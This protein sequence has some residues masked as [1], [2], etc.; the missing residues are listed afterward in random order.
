[1]REE[2]LGPFP[3]YCTNVCIVNR[4]IVSD[5]SLSEILGVTPFEQHPQIHRGDVVSVYY[6][7]S[8]S[9]RNSGTVTIWHN[10]SHAAIKTYSATLSGEWL[11]PLKLIVSD[12][13][14]VGWTENG[15]LVTGRVAIDINGTEGVYSCGEFFP[16]SAQSIA[17]G[18]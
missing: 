4:K 8:G 14:E 12:D 16:T 10:R 6:F 5:E 18:Y 7:H 13:E 11:Q 1:M 3:A 9:L 2:D 15:Q 17:V